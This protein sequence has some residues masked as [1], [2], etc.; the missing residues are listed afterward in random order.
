MNVEIV[1]TSLVTRETS[2]P[3]R[4]AF[5]V[6]T[7]RSCTCRNAFVRNVARPASVARKI[8]TFATYDETPV[9]A[10]P[11]AA[12]STSAA[13]SPGRAPPGELIPRSTVCWTAIGT[14]TRPA[15]ETRATRPGD[16]DA[17]GDLG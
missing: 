12:A 10:T 9:T 4:S 8:R 13:T 16:P 6:S 14:T 1:S 15:V 11:T 2:A 7:D 3:R 17:T 5:W